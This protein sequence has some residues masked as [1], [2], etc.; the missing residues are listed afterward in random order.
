MGDFFLFY[1]NV[2]IRIKFKEIQLSQKDE[3]DYPNL[4]ELYPDI[5]KTKSEFFVWLR[6]GLRRAI[7]EKYPVK[8]Q[9]KNET[10]D[11]PPEG[12]TGRAKSGKECALSGEWTGKSALEVDHIVGNASLRDW[13]D[14]PSFVAHL[15]TTKENMQLVS[16][17][18]HKIK[19]YA[20]RYN[21]SYAEAVIEKEVVAICKKKVPELDKWIKDNGGVEC[22]NATQRR[23]MVRT[24]LLNKNKKK[25]ET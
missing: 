13:E 2:N 10:V 21:M 20:E 25:K 19:S 14:I 23:T 8:I 16:K 4:W 17:E 12:Y 9:F 15:C 24:L 5:W 6:G 18:A 11:L 3:V 1:I 7:W 22:K